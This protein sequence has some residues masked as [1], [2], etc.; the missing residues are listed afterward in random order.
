MQRGQK[1]LVDHWVAVTFQ[2]PDKQIL[3]C[4]SV[5]SSPV[6]SIIR[7]VDEGVPP[8]IDRAIKE[9]LFFCNI[10]V[11]YYIAVITFLP[12]LRVSQVLNVTNYRDNKSLVS[13]QPLLTKSIEEIVRHFRR[14][15]ALSA[16]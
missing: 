16:S 14:T 1:L 10:M 8:Q 2:P 13:D 6:A 7:F 15:G 5:K 4:D 11:L 12:A 3:V 9:C